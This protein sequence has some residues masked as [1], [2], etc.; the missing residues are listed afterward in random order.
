MKILNQFANNLTPDGQ[1]DFLFYQS[2]F[3]FFQF[4]DT[5]YSIFIA[6]FKFSDKFRY[7]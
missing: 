5:F 2:F 4:S 3:D 1:L 6:V 7:K